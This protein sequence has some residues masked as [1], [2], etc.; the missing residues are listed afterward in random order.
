[1]ASREFTDRSGVVWRVW[2]VRPT[3]LHPVTRGEDFMGDFADGWLTFE[4]PSERRRLPAPYPAAWTSFDLPK[5]EALCRAAKPVSARKNRTPSGEQLALTEDTA[6]R[7]ARA[8]DYAPVELGFAEERLA[9]ARLA[10]DEG[11]YEVA[12]VEAEQAEVNAALAAAR[13]RAAR[14]RKAVQ[15]QAEEN[16][17]LRRELLPAGERP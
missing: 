16:A 1:M 4:S 9:D 14:G 8:D 11:D 7:A 2:D 3:S 17:R 6:A 12:R 15:A 13:S 5:L 10:M